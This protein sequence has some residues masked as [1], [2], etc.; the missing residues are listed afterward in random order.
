MHRFTRV[1]VESIR[2]FILYLLTLC[3]HVQLQTV[4]AT[5]V[6]VVKVTKVLVFS[7]WFCCKQ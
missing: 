1:A 5:V 6:K 3:K 7:K 2:I 4:T